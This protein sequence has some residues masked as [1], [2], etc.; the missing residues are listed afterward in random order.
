MKIR[1]VPTYFSDTFK[2]RTLLLPMQ[3][4]YIYETKEEA[5]RCMDNLL[6][7]MDSIHSPAEI[8]SLEV[9]PCQCYD[10]HFD[11]MNCW[12]EDEQD[13]FSVQHDPVPIREMLNKIEQIK[14][15]NKD[16]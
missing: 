10:R 3:G 15:E 14:E 16:K 9:R 8:K 7:G 4:R 12:F 1:F 11:P 2:M 5:Q 13:S 6:P